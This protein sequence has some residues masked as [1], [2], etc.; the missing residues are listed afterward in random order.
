M[1]L[2]IVVVAY[3]SDDFLLNCLE[4][5]YKYIDVESFEVIVS[6]NKYDHKLVLPDYKNLHTINN[7]ENY[8]FAKALNISIKLE[9]ND[10]IP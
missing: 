3:N 4:S 9:G 5:L 1:N 6:N 7:L 8:G 10:L 2:S